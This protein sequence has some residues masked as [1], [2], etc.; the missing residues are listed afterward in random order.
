MRRWISGGGGA[1]TRVVPLRASRKLAS[2]ATVGPLLAILLV[3][4][5]G[6]DSSPVLDAGDT[7]AG[8]PS[9]RRAAVIGVVD[10]VIV[11]T[12][13]GFREETGTLLGALEDGD[14]DAARAAWIGAIDVW[15]EVELM[16]VGPTGAMDATTGGEDFRDAI[17]SWPIVNRCRVDQELVEQAYADVDAFATE[18]VN[19][20]GLD[21][22][23]YLLFHEGDDNGCAPNS[24]IN[25]DGLWSPIVAELPARRLAYATTLATLVRRAASELVDS[26]A[27]FA[28]QM[29]SAGASS[30]VF[31]SSQAALNALSDALFYLDK[32]T[33]DMKLAVPAG[34]SADCAAET[35]PELRES[36]YADRSRE[37]VHA[38][39]RGF[40]EVYRGGEG[41]GFDDLLRAEGATT[42]ADDLDAA[43]D[44][45]L[46]AIDAVDGSMVDALEAD[47][48]AM[49]ASYDAVKRIT[50]LLKTELVTVL[51]LELPMR[52]EGDND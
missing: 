7:D 40:A 35:C 36:L 46:A 17:Y 32:E 2:L 12:L 19:V 29:R 30:T 24:A 27:S 6:D 52:A 28:E 38:N 16:Q 31:E 18:N 23:E 11:P 48:G 14:L 3:A 41:Y 13:T 47:P 9:P 5:G 42:L 8:P 4:C 1:S 21:A 34:I 22:M 25:R 37:H 45:A 20:R 39:V 50:D 49:Q 15:Q 44:D 43:I 51:D 26:W 33:K 10:E